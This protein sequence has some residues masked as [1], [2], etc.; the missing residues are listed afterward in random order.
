MYYM[1]Y[2]FASLHFAVVNRARAAMQY[3]PKPL[4]I[5][6]HFND[7]IKRMHVAICILQL[8]SCTKLINRKHA[9]R[10]QCWT[11]EITVFCA[12]LWLF[13]WGL[14]RWYSIP[15]QSS[16]AVLVSFHDTCRWRVSFIKSTKDRCGALYNFAM[17]TKRNAFRTI[18]NSICVP[19]TCKPNHA[20]FAAHIVC[21]STWLYSYSVVSF[22]R[23]ATN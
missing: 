3:T 2:T 20:S 4:N 17:N 18:W 13:R 16:S 5:P 14:S 7:I 6:R 21:L 19:F 23:G 10:V 8:R 1:C 15:Y 12:L 11:M 22:T 9:I